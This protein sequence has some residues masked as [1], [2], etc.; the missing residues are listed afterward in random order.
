M[1]ATWCAPR[2]PTLVSRL[3]IC[4]GIVIQAAERGN[5]AAVHTEHRGHTGATR[6]VHRWHLSAMLAWD[7]TRKQTATGLQSGRREPRWRG[8][9]YNY[10]S[11]WPGAS[12]TFEFAE[13]HERLRA[14]QALASSTVHLGPAEGK[15]QPF[16]RSYYNVSAKA[17]IGSTL[18]N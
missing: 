10:T 9:D 12:L 16:L 6:L 11:I 13:F 3:Q 1:L 8:C 5:W 7:Q 18:D 17:K 2:A 14:T 4:S 15:L